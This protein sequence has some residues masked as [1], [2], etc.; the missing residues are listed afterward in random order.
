MD[1]MEAMEFWAKSVSGI[2]ILIVL[3]TAIVHGCFGV[4]VY[5][6]AKRLPRKPILVP[7]VVWSLAAILGG[8]FVAAVY[9]VIHHSR[10]NPWIDVT[11]PEDSNDSQNGV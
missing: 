11:P 2:S 5:L 3:L 1:V 7:P 10:L 9:W 6:D 8:L 4:G